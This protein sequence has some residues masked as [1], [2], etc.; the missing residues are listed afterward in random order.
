[1]FY[2]ILKHRKSRGHKPANFHESVTV[3]IVWTVVPFLIVIGM[4]HGHATKVVG[5]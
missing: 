1:M 2:S 4:A 3:E 5:A